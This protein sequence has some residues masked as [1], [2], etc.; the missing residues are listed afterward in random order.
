[1]I[2]GFDKETHELTE[3]ELK[4]LPTVVS[5]LQKKIGKENA[6][7]NKQMVDGL[8]KYGIKTSG[9]RIR[10]IIHHIRITGTI[11]R[12]MATSNGYYISNDINELDDYIKSLVQRSES[13][14]KI[15]DQLQFQRDKIL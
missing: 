2:I 7:T 15:A 13:I 11:E 5:G 9:P 3:K 1:M 4:L 10:K 8:K 14:A 6:V 12:L